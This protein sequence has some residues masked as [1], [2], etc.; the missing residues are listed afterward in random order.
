[1]CY[2]CIQVLRYLF[3]WYVDTSCPHLG[4]LGPFCWLPKRW[5]FAG[6]LQQQQ[7][8]HDRNKKLGL[9][10]HRNSP[11]ESH[12]GDTD[13]AYCRGRMVDHSSRCYAM[14]SLLPLS[15]QYLIQRKS[16]SSSSTSSSCTSSR[17]C[18]SRS[19]SSCSRSS[20]SSRRRSSSS[21]VAVAV[22]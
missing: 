5:P 14:I 10:S 19:G 22:V 2:F 20:S 21:I 15:E 1:M 17:S 7:P 16:S 11:E 4:L 6:Q 12:G 8:R 9:V 3:F 13:H 18:R